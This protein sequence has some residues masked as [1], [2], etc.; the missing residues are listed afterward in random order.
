M[1]CKQLITIFLWHFRL[2]Q[3]LDTLKWKSSAEQKKLTE[4]LEKMTGLRDE[5]LQQ[6]AKEREKAILERAVMNREWEKKVDDLL[7]E[8][9]ASMPKNEARYLLIFVFQGFWF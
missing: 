6:K 5:I 9:C 1:A 4:N 3:E 2:Q 7:A 8:L